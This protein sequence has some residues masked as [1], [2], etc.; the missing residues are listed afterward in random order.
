MEG[1]MTAALVNVEVE[2]ALLGALLVNNDVLASLPSALGPSDFSE[3]LHGRL[4]EASAT[5]IRSGRPASPLLLKPTFENDET[6]KE[7]GGT[8]YLARLAAA[9]T[10]IVNAPEYARHVMGLSL[11]RKAI[12][13]AEEAIAELKD[14]PIDVDAEE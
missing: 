9:A 10:T 4:F 12:A 11:R 3:G 6:L 5:L 13:K 1:R 14:L 2:Q 7:I 8:A